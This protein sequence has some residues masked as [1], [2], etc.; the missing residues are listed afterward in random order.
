MG[1]PKPRAKAHHCAVLYI[2]TAA[3]IF[4]DALFLAADTPKAW[5]WGI[6]IDGPTATLIAVL[7]TLLVGIA[8]LILSSRIARVSADLSRVS[9]DIASQQ[10]ETA[11]TSFGLTFSIAR[12]FSKQQ[13]NF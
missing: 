6:G 2:P 8:T 3:L 1:L 13:E 7:P 11:K 9:S 10:L 5:S 4:T 12:T